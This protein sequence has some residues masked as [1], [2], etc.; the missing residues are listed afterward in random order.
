[1]SR[2]ILSPRARADLEVIWTY[3]AE[4]WGVDRADRYI[5]QLHAACETV[6]EKPERGRS[7]DDIRLG[8]RKYAV[9][10]HVLFFRVVHGNVEVV[11]VLH[12]RMD[13]NRHL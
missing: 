1:M 13:F 5:R 4:R 7:C 10:A 2:F 6:G 9:G 12:Q 11:R 8:Y 3:T